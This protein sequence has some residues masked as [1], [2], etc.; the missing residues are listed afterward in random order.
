M[1]L[2]R[3][4][5]L[6]GEDDRVQ[7]T[8]VD[9]HCLAGLEVNMPDRAWPDWADSPPSDTTC[10]TIL[11]PTVSSS[12]RYA[13]DAQGHMYIFPRVDLLR[14]LGASKRAQVQRRKRRR[15]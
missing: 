6:L 10:C 12:A 13:V 1:L 11:G 2:R 5:M 7:I 4:W 15:S 14:F 9:P 8:T 3:G